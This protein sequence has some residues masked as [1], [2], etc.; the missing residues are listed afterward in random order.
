MSIVGFNFNVILPLLASSTLHTGPRTFG[1][2][3]AAF[4]AGALGGALGAATVGRASWRGLLGGLVGFSGAMLALAPLRGIVSCGILLFA[5][6]ASFTLLTANA[7]AL[8]QTGAPDHLRG[9]VMSLYL[10]AFAGLA[11]VGGLVA[12]W[13]VQIGGT[14]LSFGVAGLTGLAVA[15]YALRQRP[16]ALTA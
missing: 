8:V 2:L 9:R 3:S 7:N 11:P 1:V 4:G 12:G 14:R 10:F 5:L 13:L 6:G 16:A 15:A